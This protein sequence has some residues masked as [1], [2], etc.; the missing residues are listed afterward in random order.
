[1]IKLFVIS[2][3]ACGLMLLPNM[4][5][6]QEFSDKDS[7]I[8][9][10]G[11][12][13]NAKNYQKALL[14][15]NEALASYPQDYILYYWR[16][17]IYSA[18]G[19]KKSALADYDKAIALEPENAKLYLMRGIC[20]YSLKDETGALNDYN[21]TIELDPNNGSAYSMRAMIK[22]DNGDYDGADKDLDKANLLLN[23]D[24]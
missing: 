11:M 16:A 22:L 23:E 18:T 13:V 20:K 15:C 21:K 9:Q 4:A 14:R 1:M 2:V 17:A 3:L 5:Y 6:S 19:D 10:I 12:M 24:N 7:L 8:T